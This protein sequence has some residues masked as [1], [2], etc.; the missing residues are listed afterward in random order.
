MIDYACPYCTTQGT[1]GPENLSIIRYKACGLSAREHKQVV[2]AW[3]QSQA[4]AEQQVRSIVFQ[5]RMN[6]LYPKAVIKAV[7]DRG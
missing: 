2:R 1:Y 3:R 6:T 4:R 5:A 7:Y